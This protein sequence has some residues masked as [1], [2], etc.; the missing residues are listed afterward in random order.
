MAR[1]DKF[2]AAINFICAGLQFDTAVEAASDGRSWV[3][4]GALTVGFI[5]VSVG[6]LVMWERR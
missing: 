2:L 1:C 3:A 5:N 4:L 6:T